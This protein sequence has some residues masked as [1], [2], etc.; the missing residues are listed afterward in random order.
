MK[1]YIHVHVGGELLGGDCCLMQGCTM[2]KALSNLHVCLVV[3][4]WSARVADLERAGT[5]MYL[6]YSSRSIRDAYW[7]DIWLTK[8]QLADDAALLATTPA[9]TEQVMLVYT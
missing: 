5:Y 9:G 2:A 3:E 7:Y 1:T 8:C 6:R 4:R